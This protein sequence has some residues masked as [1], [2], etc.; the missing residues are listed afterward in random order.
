LIIF[1]HRQESQPIWTELKRANAR[2]KLYVPGGVQIGHIP[3]AHAPAGG[4]GCKNTAIRGETC[5]GDPGAVDYPFDRFCSAGRIP[6]TNRLSI[7]PRQESS[8][9]R[10]KPHHRNRSP[11]LEWRCDGL[12]GLAVPDS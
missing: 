11:I 2:G 1:G 8:S 4:A 12:A 9:R 5:V 10:M 7:A 6:K 3:K